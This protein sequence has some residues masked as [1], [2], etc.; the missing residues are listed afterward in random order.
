M[1]WKGAF[2]GAV[3]GLMATRTVLGAF[4]GAI[5]GILI[6]QSG[7]LGAVPGARRA[8]DSLSI[9]DEFFR[10]TFELMG[11]VAKSDGRV[12]E[13]EIDAARRLMHELHLGPR[14][15]GI[16]IACFQAGKSTAYDAELGVERLRDACGQ[17]YDLLRAFMELQLRA[18]LA[19]N[20]LS[21]PA[22]AILMR[23]AERLG[24]SA[25]EFAYM[26]SALRARAAH[27]SRQ[28]HGG[29]AGPR[30]ASGAGSLAGCY[31]ELEVDANIS[32]QEV[33]KA[34][35]RQMSRHHPDK[36]V[37][38]GLPESM[39]QMAKEKTQRI[40]EAYEGIR[41]ARGMR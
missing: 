4:F 12:T 19:G 3:I 9:S 21:P 37:A 35:R 34:Y 10:T 20:G 2:L 36:L 30:P 17:R 25:L 38:N 28:A 26:E 7:A 6:E 5:I 41:A 23:V 40:Q 22:R 24:M 8:P 15:I 13:A 29:S 18:A 11:H 27:A 33:T 14:E 31:A 39:A 1:S 16:A 32:D